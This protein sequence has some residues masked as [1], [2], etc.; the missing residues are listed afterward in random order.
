MQQKHPSLDPGHLPAPSR[1]HREYTRHFTRDVKISKG[2]H[3]ARIIS[4]LPSTHHTYHACHSTWDVESLV[5][6]CTFCFLFFFWQPWAG[7]DATSTGSIESDTESCLLLCSG[8]Q[9]EQSTAANSLLSTAQTL[10]KQLAP[11]TPVP[12]PQS[13]FLNLPN[14]NL[15]NLLGGGSPGNQQGPNLAAL[16]PGNNQVPAPSFLHA[17]L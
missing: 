6:C 14:I 10:A 13:N 15:Q 17:L 9:A 12:T 4:T 11:A 1:G 7:N 5:R 2:S 3:K 16:I 8:N